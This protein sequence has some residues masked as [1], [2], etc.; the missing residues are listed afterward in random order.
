MSAREAHEAGFV[1]LVVGA[2]QALVEAR[3][4]ARQ[5]AALPA[6]T[7]AIFRRLLRRSAK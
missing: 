6:Q 5:I 4:V 2:G 3:K 7:V 1:N